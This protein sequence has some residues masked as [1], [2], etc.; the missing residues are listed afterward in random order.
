MS[1]ITRCTACGTMFKVVPDQ[2]KMGEGWVRCGQC[3]EVFD[4]AAHLQSS[5]AEGGSP[6]PVDPPVA[7]RV[8][9]VEAA[10]VEDHFPDLPKARVAEPSDLEPVA[11]PTALDAESPSLGHEETPPPLEESG[12]QASGEEGQDPSPLLLHTAVHDEVLDMEP[13]AQPALDAEG[14]AVLPLPEVSFVRQAERKAFWRRPVVRGFLLLLCLL[15]LGLLGLQVAVQQRDE[16][17]A[18]VPQVRPALE[19]LCRKLG[20]E[21]S[22]RRHIES[23]VIDSSSFNKTRG[24]A[25]L[26]SLTLKNTAATALATPALE[27]TLTDVQDQPVLRRVLQPADLGLGAELPAHGEAAVALPIGLSGDVGSARVAG[28]RLL[29]F[30]P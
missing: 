21:V 14:A 23:V 7:P 18:R 17:A 22:A 16:I 24:E 10:E 11:E 12:S 1:L 26:L 30:Y 8:E 6:R 25:Y 20:C 28:Y 27:L 5:A 13:L 4:A 3:S 15:L 2:L 9:T 29:A 19:A